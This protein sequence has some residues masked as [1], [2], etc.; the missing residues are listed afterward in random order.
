LPGLDW[1][2]SNLDAVVDRHEH[3]GPAVA[4]DIGGAHVEHAAAEF[5]P[6][7]LVTPGRRAAV[8]CRKA[9]CC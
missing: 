8:R 1:L 7:V 6:A 9:T 5:D 3:V 2:R 4:V